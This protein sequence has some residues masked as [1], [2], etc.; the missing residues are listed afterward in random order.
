MKYS[1]K[2]KVPPGEEKVFDPELMQFPT[3]VGA[4]LTAARNGQ[5]SFL[6]TFGLEG[7][8]DALFLA[9]DADLNPYHPDDMKLLLRS[10]PGLLDAALV[11]LGMYTLATR[12]APVRKVA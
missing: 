9:L 1:K 6:E 5:W 8:N 12:P 7:Q 11:A 10:I 2:H 3:A 4:I